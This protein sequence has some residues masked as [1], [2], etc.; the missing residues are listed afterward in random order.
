MKWGTDRGQSGVTEE[1]GVV[2]SGCA[3]EGQGEVCGVALT[4]NSDL[5]ILIKVVTP[6]CSAM[7]SR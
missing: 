1:V 4:P 5:D 2:R 3:R 7:G 6:N